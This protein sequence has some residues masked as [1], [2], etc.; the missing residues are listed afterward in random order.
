MG[1]WLYPLVAVAILVAA[2]APGAPVGLPS[3]NDLANASPQLLLAIGFGLVAT[4]KLNP[5]SL[6]DRAEARATLATE[7][8][9]KSNTATAEAVAAV[10]ALTVEHEEERRGW[11][12]ELSG[13][14]RELARITGNSATRG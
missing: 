4:G 9:T 10:K 8:T 3:F 2:D 11:E 13:L 14:Q 6:L 5:S 12:R 1:P 7:A